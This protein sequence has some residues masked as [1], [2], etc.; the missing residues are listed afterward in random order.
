M[1]PQSTPPAELCLQSLLVCL[2]DMR[3]QQEIKYFYLSTRWKVNLFFV[4]SRFPTKSVTC[5]RLKCSRLLWF[6]FHVNNCSRIYL[7]RSWIAFLTGSRCHLYFIGLCCLPIQIWFYWNNWRVLLLTWSILAAWEISNKEMWAKSCRFNW[8]LEEERCSLYN[9]HP[10]LGHPK[11]IFFLSRV[12]FSIDFGFLLNFCCT[13]FFPIQLYSMQFKALA[14]PAALK[15]GILN[16][17]WVL[18]YNDWG[19]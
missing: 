16:A 6:K 8:E 10:S 13:H 9:S 18:N 2:A 3:W 11:P 15:A 17:L 7:P 4:D 5:K 19:F 1:K 12:I 14:A